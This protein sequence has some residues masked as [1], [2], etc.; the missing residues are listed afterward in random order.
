MIKVLFNFINVNNYFFP[1]ITK[2]QHFAQ[3]HMLSQARCSKT[4]G[5]PVLEATNC[6]DYYLPYGYSNLFADF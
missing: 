1:E 3:K 4:L 6:T 2:I 5:I